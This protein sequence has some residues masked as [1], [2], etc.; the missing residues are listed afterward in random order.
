MPKGIDLKFTYGQKES[1]R[2]HTLIIAKS[3]E[4]D[5]IRYIYPI[6]IFYHENVAEKT[7]LVTIQCSFLR[8]YGATALT[9]TS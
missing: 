3:S 4:Y 9:F 1:I 8:F 7:V 5:K 2:T 6:T